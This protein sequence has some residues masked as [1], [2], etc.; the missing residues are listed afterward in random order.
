MTEQESAARAG[1]TW[2]EVHDEQFTSEALAAELERRV[3]ARRAELGS[4]DL[5]LPTFG[6]ISTFPEPPAG[7]VYDAN[8]YYHLKQANQARPAVLEPL[9]AP[10]PA[11]RLP[12]LGRLWGL[13][14][15]EMHQL[16]L[17]YVNRAASSQN[18]L[19]TDVVSTLNELTRLCQVQGAEIE[20]LRDELQRLKE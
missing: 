13:I 5:I 11:T 6:R 7:R 12:V 19:N 16:I 8:L 20:R 1:Q 3:A 17:F 14:R 2:I 18:R 4:V 15:G 9:L 10:S